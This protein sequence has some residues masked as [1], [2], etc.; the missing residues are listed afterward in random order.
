MSR[1]IINIKE[2]F[3]LKYD[4]KD[5]G[6]YIQKLRLQRKWS[7]HKLAYRS[8]INNTVLMRIEKGEREPKLNTIIKIADGLNLSL[9]DFFKP[10]QSR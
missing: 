9:A 6:K 2:E 8:C 3:D 4:A 5:I 10:F 7:M 1:E